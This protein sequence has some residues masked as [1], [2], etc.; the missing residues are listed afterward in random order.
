MG[1]SEN[2]VRRDPPLLEAR[3]VAFATLDRLRG[4]AD[5]KRPDLVPAFG[6]ANGRFWRPDALGVAV[7]AQSRLCRRVLLHHPRAEFKHR[8]DRYCD[9]RRETDVLAPSGPAVAVGGWPLSTAGAI[10]IE[11]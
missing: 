9:R 5:R 3:H 10:T 7:P 6:G 11:G 8:A 4:L 2:T 1:L